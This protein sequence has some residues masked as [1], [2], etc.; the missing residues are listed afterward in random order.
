V[1]I[2]RISAETV[3]SAQSN[4]GPWH[5][6]RDPHGAPFCDRARNLPPLSTCSTARIQCS[7]T[8]KRL[9]ASVTKAAKGW[10][11]KPF[12]RRVVDDPAQ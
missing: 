6:L 2:V 1:W 12:G 8:R 11:V 3:A 4:P 7:G 10:M 9:D 5:D